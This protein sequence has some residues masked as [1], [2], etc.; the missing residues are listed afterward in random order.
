MDVTITRIKAVESLIVSVV[1]SACNITLK[2]SYPK[3]LKNKYYRWLKYNC[4]IGHIAH[5]GNNYHNYIS[6]MESD[7]T[8]IFFS[9]YSL[10]ER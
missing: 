1:N 7:K 4:T 5:L 6:F 10:H 3:Y 2:Q 8:V 9:R